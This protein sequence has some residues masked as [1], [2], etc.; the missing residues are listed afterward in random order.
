M[1]IKTNDD[2]LVTID[3]KTQS[4]E[5]ESLDT[6]RKNLKDFKL[7]TH[8]LQTENDILRQHNI[9]LLRELDAERNRLAISPD[10][11]QLNP[12]TGLPGQAACAKT[13]SNILI[14]HQ[15]SSERSM[16]GTRS[17]A[18][19]SLLHIR[20]D[21][22]F[23]LVVRTLKEDAS[24]WILYQIGMRIRE[25]LSIHDKLFH[26]ADD[27]FVAILED[28]L[29]KDLP[30][31][32]N[33]LQ[34]SIEKHHALAG[35][36]LQ[37]GAN[38]GLAVYP[39]HGRSVAALN[40]AANIALSEAIKVGQPWVIFKDQLRKDV[41][42]RMELQN[43]ILRALEA[44]AEGGR[45]SQFHLV[46]QPQVSLV[47][48]TRGGLAISSINAEVLLR[49]KHPQRGLIPP[50]H[51]IPLAEETG[52]IQ[53]LGT[54]LIYRTAE[55]LAQWKGTNLEPLVLSVNVSPSQFQNDQLVWTLDHLTRNNPGIAQRMK[56]EITESSLL[57]NPDSCLKYMHYLRSL[58]LK[59]AVDDFGRDYSSL[60]YLRRLPVNTLK[61][62]KSFVTN[63]HQDHQSRLIIRAIAH[64]ARDLKLKVIVEGVETTKQLIPLLEEGCTTI[65]GFLFSRPIT[66]SQLGE[67]YSRC[68]NRRI[69]LPSSI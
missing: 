2:I 43:G 10:R 53:P 28:R 38:F 35:V 26:V 59:F 33:Q 11:L 41:V 25:S 29:P 23:S 22:Q 1:H 46:F 61:I 8:H 58:G 47:R 36:R 45:K 3:M 66:A 69:S 42:E 7:K 15:T 17:D 24:S 34:T 9:V 57:K 14:S 50:S 64:L 55:F 40:H 67:F 20:L 12:F 52:L 5:R 13:L 48:G 6:L 31:Y 19:F 54:W 32:L 27:E 21:H 37:I 4:L 68:L 30:R 65:Q 44:Q 56:L 39:Y 60:S 49:W 16:S 18:S 63:I 51:F 62:D